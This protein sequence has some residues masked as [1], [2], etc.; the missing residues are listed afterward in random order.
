ME[1]GVV[2]CEI[3]NFKLRDFSRIFSRTFS[4]FFR[5]FSDFEHIY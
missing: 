4:E 3:F 1:K 2:F 5:D